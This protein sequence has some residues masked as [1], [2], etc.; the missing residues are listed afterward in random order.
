[1]FQDGQPVTA[2]HV[3]P[4]NEGLG[5][6]A[7]NALH[8]RFEMERG[9]MAYFA[10]VANDGTQN[11]GFGLHLVGSKGILTIHA[12]RQ[13][14]AYWV[15]G[16]PLG[17][18]R[19]SRPWIPFTTGGPGQEEPDL[20]AVQAVQNHVTPALDL[21]RAIHEDRQPLCDLAEGGMTVEMICAVF[22]SQRQNGAAV[23]IPLKERGNALSKL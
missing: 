16:N 7:G 19:E 22:E 3:K 18:S 6:L 17:P 23:T 13:P 2:A 12:D 10:S 14:L 15:P 8:A 4:G 5:P 21:V 20:A 1:M 11:P 9:M